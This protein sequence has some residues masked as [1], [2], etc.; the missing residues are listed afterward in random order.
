MF[1]TVKQWKT[2]HIFPMVFPRFLPFSEIFPMFLLAP[3]V[4]PSCLATISASPRL[5]PPQGRAA[6]ALVLRPEIYSPPHRCSCTPWGR[7]RGSCS[8][9]QYISVCVLKSMH[10][11]IYT[12]IYIYTLIC[13][14]VY[15]YIYIYI[16]I[17]TYVY[18]YM[19]IYIYISTHVVI[20]E[21]TSMYTYI[22]VFMYMCRCIICV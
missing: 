21:W 2:S 4:K 3:T 9:Y 12:Y 6:S 18:L 10:M 11:S 14:Y 20:I 19:Y 16:H 5:R 1:Q 7:T 13:M 17:C 8:M 15:I 22:H